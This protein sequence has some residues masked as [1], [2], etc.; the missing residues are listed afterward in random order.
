MT[1]GTAS[2]DRPRV[3]GL[4]PARGGSKGVPRK[5]IKPLGGRPLVCWTIH[6]ALAARTLSAIVVSTDDE[7]I[8]EVSREA[9]AEVPFL[10][11]PELATDSAATLP[12][13]LDT[14]DRL[15]TTHGEFDAVCLLQPTSPFRP[16][17]RIDEAVERL[18]TERADSVVSVRRI[19][20]EHHPDWALVCRADGTAGWATGRQEPPARRQEL[21]PAFHREG[22]IYVT[23][24]EV[25]RGG[26]LF[27]TRMVLSE[28]TGA[29]VNIDTV[30]DW[31]QAEQIAAAL[32]PSD[33][34]DRHR[35]EAASLV[36]PND[37]SAE[38]RLGEA[39]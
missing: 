11:P 15:R 20:A 37:G 6:P 25:L 5:N 2:G 34:R 1:D 17:E 33:R 9:G 30:E 19:P 39:Q 4:I 12:V 13:I 14:L 28:V 27:G 7:E 32:R 35:P 3:L 18:S 21:E 31:E 8:A 29:T 10:R 26:S 22:S 38:D 24:T 16:S 23:R 36:D